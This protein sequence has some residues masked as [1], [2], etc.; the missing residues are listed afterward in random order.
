MTAWQDNPVILEK[1]N[2]V[3]SSQCNFRH[4]WLCQITDRKLEL[5][6]SKVPERPSSL[7]ILW[8]PV[9]KLLSRQV[10]G[11]WWIQSF[12]EFPAFRQK[13]EVREVLKIQGNLEKVGNFYILEIIGLLNKAKL[14]KFSSQN[15]IDF[16]ALW[17]EKMDYCLCLIISSLTQDALHNIYKRDFMA[18]WHHVKD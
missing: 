16:I 8:L 15:I 7:K 17:R 4:F 3:I 5:Y 14:G 9:R 6:L 10:T 2:F 11:K 13:L 1:Y 18:L 12:P